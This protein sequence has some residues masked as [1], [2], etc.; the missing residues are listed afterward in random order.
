MLPPMGDGRQP[1]D[2]APRPDLVF[3]HERIGM[4]ERRDREAQGDRFTASY[5]HR[6]LG[7]TVRTEATQVPD[8]VTATGRIPLLPLEIGRVHDRLDEKRGP[9]GFPAIAAMADRRVMGITGDAVAGV[10][11]EATAL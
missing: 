1:R 2:P 7:T 10:P 9:G 4:I 3:R 8:R 11:A 6:Q 5:L